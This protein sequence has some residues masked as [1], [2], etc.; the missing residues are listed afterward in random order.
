[1]SNLR[2]TEFQTPAKD[3]SEYGLGR[4]LASTYLK[5]SPPEDLKDFQ[6]RGRT[7]AFENGFFDRIREEFSRIGTKDSLGV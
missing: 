1:M 3:L 7:E 5:K 4:A 2:L 6:I